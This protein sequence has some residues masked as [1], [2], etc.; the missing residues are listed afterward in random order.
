MSKP[1][2]PT[3]YGGGYEVGYGKPPKHTRFKPGQSGNPAGRKPRIATSALSEI[4]MFEAET[5]R[6]VTVASNGRK[7]KLSLY[8]LAL[9]QQ[10]TKAAKGDTRAMECIARLRNRLPEQRAQSEAPKGPMRVTLKL[11][12][13]DFRPPLFKDDD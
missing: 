5:G 8:Q 2:E 3:G 4:E 11:G 7:E 12:E 10:M 1:I 6:I 9:R 13:P